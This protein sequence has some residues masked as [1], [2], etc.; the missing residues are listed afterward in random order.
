MACCDHFHLPNH[1]SPEVAGPQCTQCRNKKL[2]KVSPS[3][4][5]LFTTSK[6]ISFPKSNEILCQTSSANGENV[7]TME[8]FK[9]CVLTFHN[10]TFVA[11]Y[12]SNIEKRYSTVKLHSPDLNSETY[13]LTFLTR[14]IAGNLRLVVIFELNGNAIKTEIMGETQWETFSMILHENMVTVLIDNTQWH[15]QYRNILSS[16]SIYNAFFNVNHDKTEI[17]NITFSYFFQNSTNKLKYTIPNNRPVDTNTF[18]FDYSEGGI[19][20]LRDIC[21]GGVTPITIYVQNMNIALGPNNRIPII[22]T[23]IKSDQGL[24]SNSYITQAYLSQNLLIGTRFDVLQQDTSYN[25]QSKLTSGKTVMQ[26]LSYVNTDG[27]GQIL[28]D[29]QVYM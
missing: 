20:E 21:G 11:D 13:G 8:G 9:T 5:T 26:Q 23:M 12:V 25:I 10:P 15:L 19:H 6:N 18:R 14:N 16:T 24:S 28:S 3:L 2:R 27:S 22:S 29:I 4:F 17:K 7:K 1:N